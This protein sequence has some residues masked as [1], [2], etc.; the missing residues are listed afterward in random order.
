MV[1]VCD[2][3]VNRS[4]IGFSTGAEIVRQRNE[5]QL[6]EDLEKEAATRGAAE[7][8]D[9]DYGWRFLIVGSAL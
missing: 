7:P 9:G 5:E 3:T 2:K 4:E 6:I 1:W 8:K